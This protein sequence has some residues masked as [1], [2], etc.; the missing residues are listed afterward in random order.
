M[1]AVSSPSAVCVGRRRR[2]P[3]R[4]GRGGDRGRDP[5][6]GDSRRRKRKSPGRNRMAV[7][8]TQHV[9]D[10]GRR[11]QPYDRRARRRPTLPRPGVARRVGRDRRWA[12]RAPIHAASSMVLMALQRSAGNAAVRSLDRRPCHRRPSSATMPRAPPRP[13]PA[14]QVRSHPRPPPHRRARGRWPERRRRRPAAGAECARR[15]HATAPDHGVFDLMTAA[16]RGLVPGGQPAAGRRRRVWPRYVGQDR[17]ARAT[18][19]P[20]GPERRRGSSP[21]RAA[22]SAARRDDPPDGPPALQGPGGRGA[23]AEAQ[24]RAVGPGPDDARRRRRLRRPDRPGGQG[25]PALPNAGPRRRRRRRAPDL[26]GV[27]RGIRRR[28]RRPGRSSIGSSVRRAR[29]PAVP[30]HSRGGSCPIV[31]RRRSTSRSPA[32]RITRVWPSGGPTSP[33]CGTRSGSRTPTTPAIRSTSSSSPG[34]ARRPMP[35][36]TSSSRLRARRRDARIRHTGTRAT[37][38]R[39]SRRTSSVT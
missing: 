14:R 22:W 11:R 37:R 15:G 1:S 32:R 38:T 2:R 34:R 6:R 9:H 39:A 31:S 12:T 16:R 17:R 35:R 3:A 21:G 10:H 23:P 27:G 33:G 7:T 28:R 8:A 5:A 36:S 30:P 19:L 4:R 18:G 13:R 29:S 26:V 25:V 20:P 24:Q